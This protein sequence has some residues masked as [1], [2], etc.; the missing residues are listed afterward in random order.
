MLIPHGTIVAVADGEILNLFRN[1]GTDAAPKLTAMPD[2]EVSTENMG[3]AAVTR[4]APPTR[5]TANRMKTALP[6]VLPKCLTSACS[7]ARST[8]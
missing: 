3:S 6:L 2:A 4:A 1:T 5:R 8:T 7:M